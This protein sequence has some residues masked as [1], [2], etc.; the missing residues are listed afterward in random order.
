MNFLSNLRSDPQIQSKCSKNL[1]LFLID[2]LLD[3]QNLK[4]VFGNVLR[5][6]SRYTA[7]PE[8]ESGMEFE[9]SNFVYN[10]NNVYNDDNNNNIDNNSQ[11]YDSIKCLNLKIH[12]NCSLYI[13]RKC[14][15]ISTASS[16]SSTT[17]YS[18]KELIFSAAWQQNLW[19]SRCPCGSLRRIF[20]IKS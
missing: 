15:R 11:F 14:Q 18:K 16:K 1:F 4:K 19:K 6:F 7:A 3:S 13:C 10:N 20:R 17:K 5:I 2:F 12:E 9:D 8:C